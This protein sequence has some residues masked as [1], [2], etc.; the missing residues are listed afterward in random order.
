MSNSFV[1]FVTEGLLLTL[2]SSC[3]FMSSS[4]YARAARGRRPARAASHGPTASRP[5][6]PQPQARNSSDPSTERRVLNG[7]F[8]KKPLRKI[9]PD[10]SR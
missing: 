1:H 5:R 2:L 10:L 9:N 7:I 8:K 3:N 6:P 4:F